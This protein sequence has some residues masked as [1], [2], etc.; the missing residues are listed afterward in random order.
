[1]A[2]V[3]KRVANRLALVSNASAIC[4]TWHSWQLPY[5]TSRPRIRTGGPAPPPARH[6]RRGWACRGHDELVAPVGAHLGRAPRV[7]KPDGLPV[8]PGNH[9][10]SARAAAG[11]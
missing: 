11:P 10:L 4:A 6:T 5:R 3:V 9:Q 8:E 1:M 2:R 7:G